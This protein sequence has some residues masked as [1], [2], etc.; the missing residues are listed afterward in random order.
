M[1]PENERWFAMVKRVLVTTLSLVVVM[2]AVACAPGATAA[3]AEVLAQPPVTDEPSPAAVSAPA[4]TTPSEEEGQSASAAP[5]GEPLPDGVSSR[6]TRGHVWAEPVFSGGK[7]TMLWSVVGLGD[8]LHFEVP[9]D[10]GA[11]E[12]ISYL[13]EEEFFVRA[14]VCPNCG[15]E[16]VEWGGTLL[17]CRACATTFDRVTG[18]ASDGGRGY[19]Q[20]SVPYEA[21]G[22]LITMSLDE[23]LLAYARTGAGE[24]TLLPV[25]VVVEDEDRGDRSWPRCCTT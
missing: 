2:L 4:P 6:T 1:K 22:D 17:A 18:E 20:G 8:H 15:D 5:E 14:A 25:D 16:R 24:E 10:E 21:E 19:P 3:P 13:F 9:G 11:L 7:V 23:L 12:F